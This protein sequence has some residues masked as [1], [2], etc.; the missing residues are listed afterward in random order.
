MEGGGFGFLTPV[1]E[2]RTNLCLLAKGFIK[3]V[4][5]KKKDS[6]KAITSSKLT[7]PLYTKS[8]KPK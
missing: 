8:M 1:P 5:K 3:I 6:P 7:A 4:A 2:A